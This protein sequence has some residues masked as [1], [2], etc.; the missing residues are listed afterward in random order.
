MRGHAAGRWVLA[1][2]AQVPV[3]TRHEIIN[4]P[5]YADTVCDRLPH[6]A[7]R[8]RYLAGDRRRRT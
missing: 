6:N 5:I 4:A 2:G 3:T 8:S 7:Q 1:G